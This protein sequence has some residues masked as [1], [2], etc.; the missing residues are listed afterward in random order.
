[1]HVTIVYLQ[2][3]GSNSCC[4]CDV[5]FSRRNEIVQVFFSAIFGNSEQKFGSTICRPKTDRTHFKTENVILLPIVV[6]KLE[7]KIKPLLLVSGSTSVVLALAEIYTVQYVINPR[8][9]MPQI[10]LELRELPTNP[11]KKPDA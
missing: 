2:L 9:C 11:V 4:C 8:N 3:H 7:T 1:M 6:D 5:L 10:H